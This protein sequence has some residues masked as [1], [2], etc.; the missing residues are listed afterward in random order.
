MLEER[1]DGDLTY[2]FKEIECNHSMFLYK[3]N[4]SEV[5]QIILKLNK[6]S[7][8]GYDNI[9]VK[10]ILLIQEKMV[11]ILTILINDIFS[12][13]IFPK[14]LKIGKVIPIHKNG[15]LTDIQNYRPITEVCTPSK[16]IEHLIKSRTIEYLAKYVKFDKYQYGFMTGSSTLSATTDFI[17]HITT[18]LDKKN[19]L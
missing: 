10:D 15:D 9:N 18:E 12:S 13:G 6:D 1:N 4:T 14:E 8:A 7:A 16:I 11:P 17:N 19:M 2:D 3:T 5:G